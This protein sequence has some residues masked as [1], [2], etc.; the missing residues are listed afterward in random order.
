M[1]NK[2]I[3]SCSTSLLIRR[4]QIKSQDTG[5][6]TNIRNILLKKKR[7]TIPSVDEDTEQLHFSNNAGGNINWNNHFGKQSIHFI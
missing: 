1:A 6:Q 2:H 7:L 5:T 4:M 3:K